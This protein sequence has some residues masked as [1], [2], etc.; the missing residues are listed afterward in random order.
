MTDIADLITRKIKM[1]QDLDRLHDQYIDDKK[2]ILKPIKDKFDA[3]R[4]CLEKQINNLTSL[5]AAN[6]HDILMNNS[7][8]DINEDVWGN[9]HRD[10]LQFEEG[11]YCSL[12]K[13]SK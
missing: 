4:R 5:I 12:N 6:A 3:K 2:R 1:K 11:S 7:P 8:R 13:N 9:N 10:S